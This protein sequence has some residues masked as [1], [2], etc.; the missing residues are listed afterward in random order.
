LYMLLL[1]IEKRVL[2]KMILLFYSLF[3]LF[4]GRIKPSWVTLAISSPD[5]VKILPLV[6]PLAPDALGD[7][8]ENNIQSLIS[9]SLKNH[10]EWSKVAIWV[11]PKCASSA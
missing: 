5:S 11:F 1:K 6:K 2:W 3:Y 8:I 9:K 7:S 4:L 10:I